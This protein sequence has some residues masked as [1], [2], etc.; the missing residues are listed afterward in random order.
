MRVKT[1]IIV[2]NPPFNFSQDYTEKEAVP[3]WGRGW[4]DH[5]LLFFPSGGLWR[6][7]ATKSFA[8]N[9]PLKNHRVQI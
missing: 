8:A 1:L 6:V 4:S 2:L 3:P 5:L 9:P 7:I